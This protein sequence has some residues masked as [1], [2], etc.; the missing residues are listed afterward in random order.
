[1]ADAFIVDAVRSPMGRFNGGLSQVH[2]AD[3]GA[4][5]IKGVLSRADVDPGAVDDCIMGCVG[6][7]G[8]QAFNVAR[9]AWIS[10]G[11]PEH[12][13]AVTID[14][15]CGSSQQAVHFA[16]MGVMSG[17]QD[18]VVAGGVEVMSLIKLNSQGEIGPPNGMRYP[19]DGEGWQRR[20]GEQEIHQFRGGNLIVDKWNLTAQE[21]CELAQ[22]SHRNAAR[23]WTEGRFDNEVLPYGECARDEG[24][25]PDTTIEKMLSLKPFSE[26]GPLNAAM[27]SQLTDGAAALLIASEK[28]VREHGLK[29]RARIRA[30]TV[31]GSDPVFILTGPIPATQKIFAKTG[32]GVDDIDLFECNEAFAS[33]VLAWMKD[34]GIP[35][36]KV[37]V[38]GGAMALG[39]PLGASGARIMTT[40]LNELERSGGRFGFQTMCEGGGLANATIIERL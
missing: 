30:M 17:V 13:P 4:H 14:R 10:A 8:A 7:I 11:L 36:D 39:H 5:V 21:M 20:F 24:L 3:L 38:N 23:A 28:A 19:F 6:Q 2:P 15:Q 26:H 25:R 29:P 9:N 34:C 33:V 18:L 37:N 35:L 31:V 1:M 12:V 27:A 22:R 16:A 32:M 40:L